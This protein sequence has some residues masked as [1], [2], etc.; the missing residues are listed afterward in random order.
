MNGRRRF[1]R[2]FVLGLALAAL[3]SSAAQAGTRP[4]DRAGPLGV[5]TPG[6]QSSAIRPDDRAGPLGVGTDVVARYLVIHQG[7]VRPDDRAGTL[8]VGT[9]QVAVDESDVITRYLGHPTAV[10]PDDRGGIR[11]VGTGTAGVVTPAPGQGGSNWG[12]AALGA[13][14]TLGA[15]AVTLAAFALMRRRRSA[16]AA[17]QS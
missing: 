8:G 16:T 9:Q 11:G 17:L 5:G 3:G 1:K 15:L 13:V 7:A 10:R 12:A 14:S 2:W 6:A 4:D